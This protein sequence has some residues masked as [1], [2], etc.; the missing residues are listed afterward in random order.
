MT[1][2][3]IAVFCAH[4]QQYSMTAVQS[5]MWARGRGRLYNSALQRLLSRSG[6]DQKPHLTINP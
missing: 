1:D 6:S 3:H 4:I 2:R 5:Q